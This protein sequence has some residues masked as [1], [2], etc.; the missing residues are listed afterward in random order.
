MSDSKAAELTLLDIRKGST[1]DYE[2][3]N[4]KTIGEYNYR[5]ADGRFS[6][7]FKLSNASTIY[8][9]EIED[10]EENFN[11]RIT[12]KIRR[13]SEIDRVIGAIRKGQTPP[14][15]IHYNG[16]DFKLTESTTGEYRDRQGYEGWESFDIWDYFDASGLFILSIERWEG[17]DFEIYH[18]HTEK[19]SSFSNIT[20]PAKRAIASNGIF[21][22]MGNNVFWVIFFCFQLMGVFW[23][24]RRY[25]TPS[26]SYHNTSSYDSQS[27][28]T[29]TS[30]STRSGGSSGYR[31]RI[32][33]SNGRSGSSSRSRSSGGK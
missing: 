11:I 8:Y 32:S 13:N 12:K 22:W 33:R 1:L 2:L 10:Q 5:W 9:L 21:R 27:D 14:E 31:S 25:S 18:G 7:E 20:A 23:S 16:R 30:S 15:S 4:W 3:K 6:R 19:K 28:T 26:S 24:S 29:A 17:D